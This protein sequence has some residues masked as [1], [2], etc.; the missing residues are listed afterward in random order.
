MFNVRCGLGVLAVL[1]VS[2]C[3]SDNEDPRDKFFKKFSLTEGEYKFNCENGAM[4]RFPAEMDANSDE[5]SCRKGSKDDQIICEAGISGCDDVVLTVDGRT[6]GIEDDYECLLNIQGVAINLVVQKY[7]ITI[8]SDNRN[9][10]QE[11]DG[12]FTI[13]F[14]GTD[15]NTG[16]PTTL[17]VACTLD[18]EIEYELMTGSRN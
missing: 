16:L 2:A 17:Q 3:S 8:E 7:E 10:R 12:T 1:A 11:L 15:P 13:P 9:A 14:Q 6:A 18:G 5:D 4:N